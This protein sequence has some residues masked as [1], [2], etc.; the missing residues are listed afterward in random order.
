MD[1]KEL[2][3]CEQIG[4]R[5]AIEAGKM[6]SSASGKSKEINEKESF[7]DLVTETDKAVEE[8]LFTEF[9]RN[10][11]NFRFIGEET[12]SKAG[13]TADPTWII[14]PIDGT[15]NFV[16]TFPFVCVSIGLTVNKV[17][18]LGIIYSPFLDKLYTG[19]KGFGAYCNGKPISVR[20]NCN[21]LNEALL[22][23]EFGSQRDEEKRNAIF[24][25]LEAVGWS[26][27]GI[28]CMGSA[29]LNFCSIAEGFADAYWEF[30]LHVWDM[31]AAIVIL[32]EA[33][34]HVIDTKG[35]P[36]DIMSRRVLGACSEQIAQ[37]LS[38][39]LPIHL[40]LERD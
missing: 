28:R 5:L 33:G 27:H 36:V 34:G 15:M 21:S 24:R 3:Q 12:S 26:C 20:K 19:R 32:T 16:H 23:F 17:P 39:K 18:V 6:M 9:K 31:T 37:Q 40:E 11:P 29:A 7:A 10:F 30:G 2:L 8:F 4:I 35:G 1:D 14:D 13:L 22:I 25:N 38:Q